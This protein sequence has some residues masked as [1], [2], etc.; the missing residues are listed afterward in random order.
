MTEFATKSKVPQ[1]QNAIQTIVVLNRVITFF[2]LN[3]RRLQLYTDLEIDI[4]FQCV[5]GENKSNLKILGF[6]LLNFVYEKNF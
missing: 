6:L 5:S 1:L 4:I 2:F 3:S